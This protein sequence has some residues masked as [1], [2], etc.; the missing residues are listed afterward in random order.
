LLSGSCEHLGSGVSDDRMDD[1]RA[2]ARASSPSLSCVCRALWSPWL[3]LDI[4]ARRASVPARCQARRHLTPWPGE[5]RCTRLVSGRVAETDSRQC[6]TPCR[7]WPTKRHGPRRGAR[8]PQIIAI[9]G[10]RDKHV[11]VQAGLQAALHPPLPARD[12]AP[13]GLHGRPRGG[14]PRLPGRPGDRAAASATPSSPSSSSARR[15]PAARAAS[16]ARSC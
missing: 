9:A 14:D 16:R 8:S 12:W 5:N 10:G 1:E 6:P 15:P 2:R 13:T 4:T 11:A 7:G 3:D